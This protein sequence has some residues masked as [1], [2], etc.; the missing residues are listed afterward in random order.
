MNKYE[1]AKEL[2][3]EIEELKDYFNKLS[4][5]RRSCGYSVDLTGLRQYC[6]TEF[7][8]KFKMKATGLR[9]S[10]LEIVQKE[11]DFIEEKIKESTERFNELT[12]D[13]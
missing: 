2:E 5:F 9:K 13:E 11:Y 12:K 3:K 4:S 6:S 1:Q 8:F 7:T 10:F